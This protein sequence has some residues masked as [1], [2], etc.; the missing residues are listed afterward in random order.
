MKTGFFYNLIQE[1]FSRAYSLTTGNEPYPLRTLLQQEYQRKAP[2]K[3][4]DVGCGSGSYALPGFDYTGID[5][6]PRYVAY[7]RK[8]R[9][10][11]FEQMPGDKILFP[12]RTFNTVICLSVGHHLPDPLLAN[13]LSEIRRVSADAG[14]FYFADVIRPITRSRLAARVLERLD[15]G[16]SFRTEAEYQRLLGAEF[17]ISERRE[18]VDQFY[19]T[20]FFTCRKM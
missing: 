20:I 16:D 10:G 17:A 19:R 13:V 7:C 1:G 14:V 5:L 9:P 11:R 15:E 8:N 12:D 18:L 2:Q 4:L 6:N 3:I